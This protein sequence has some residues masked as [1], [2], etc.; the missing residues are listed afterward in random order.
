MPG[1]LPSGRPSSYA[2]MEKIDLFAHILPPRYM[3]AVE[4][5]LAAPDASGRVAGYR[6]WFYEDTSLW[7]LDERRRALEPFDDYRQVLTLTVPPVEEL[8]APS[9]TVPLAREANDE[10]AE[11]CRTHDRFAG[12]AACLPLND[13][14]ASLAELDRATRDLGAL[15]VQLHTNVGGAPLDAPTFEPLWKRASELDAVVWLHPTRSAASWPD[16]PSETRSRFDI[17]WSIGWPYETSVAMARLVYSGVLERYPDLRV[18]THHAGGMVP[19]LS[20]R[21]VIPPELDGKQ[22]VEE[23]L[24]RQVLDYFRMFYADTAVFGAPHALRCALDFFGADHLV[25]GT[26]T[27]LGGRPLGGEPR[28]TAVIRETIRDVESLDLDDDGRKAVFHGNAE[29]LTGLAAE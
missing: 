26:D 4:R 16:Y 27:P 8:G 18:I 7:D 3:K 1:T 24:S 20:G 19:H 25:F 29:T 12:F 15:G 22:Q 28:A 5:L 21:L 11:L 14:E 17:N 6:A 13:V 10:L 2:A 9:V 23:S